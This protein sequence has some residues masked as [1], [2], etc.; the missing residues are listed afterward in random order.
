MVLC[1]HKSTRP[2]YNI[3]EPLKPWFV[4]FFIMYNIIIIL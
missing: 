1:T 4:W 2:Y 3:I